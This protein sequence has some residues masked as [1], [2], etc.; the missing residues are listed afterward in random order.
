MV[1]SDT[2]QVWF[3][4]DEFA[5]LGRT[6]SVEPLLTKARRSEGFIEAERFEH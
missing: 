3:M 6:Q 4:L 1:P 5:S 2:R